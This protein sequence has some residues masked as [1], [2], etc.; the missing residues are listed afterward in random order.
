MANKMRHLFLCC[1]IFVT[2]GAFETYNEEIN[3]YRSD[4]VE[5]DVIEHALTLETNEAMNNVFNL[6]PRNF[7]YFTTE[8]NISN[9]KIS[10]AKSMTSNSFLKSESQKLFS[11][12]Y[13]Y[14]FQLLASKFEQSEDKSWKSF[15][16]YISGLFCTSPKYFPDQETLGE[17]IARHRLQKSIF[18]QIPGETSCT[19]NL[20][21]FL[22]LFPSKGKFGLSSLVKPK[23]VFSSSFHF[24]ELIFEKKMKTKISLKIGYQASEEVSFESFKNDESLDVF[25]IN[26]QKIKF[27]EKQ[28]VTIYNIKN[29]ETSFQVYKEEEMC[30]DIVKSSSRKSLVSDEIFIKIKNTCQEKQLFKLIEPVPSFIR[31]QPSSLSIKRNSEDL[32][33][34]WFAYNSEK[35][36]ELDQVE[37]YLPKLDEDSLGFF[38]IRTFLGSNETLEVHYFFKKKFKHRESFPFDPSRGISLPGSVLIGD[39]SY[40]SNSLV[41]RLPQPDHSMPF[42]VITLSST[43]IALSVGSFANIFIRKPQKRKTKNFRE[44]VASL[45]KRFVKIGSEEA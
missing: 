12:S 35:A 24:Y 10:F 1:L 9:I 40:Y 25:F 18:I 38:S 28:K 5:N 16:Q 8:H 14:G 26:E 3:I 29:K 4:K 27:Y 7:I 34:T 33:L 42:N 19:E 21:S 37:L 6:F 2:C 43:L 44:K 36:R 39:K 22:N 13:P 15:V 11:E 23:D 17:A 41:I 31:F 32:V 20:F 30:F 45:V